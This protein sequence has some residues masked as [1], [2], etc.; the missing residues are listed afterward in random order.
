MSAYIFEMD[1]PKK[2]K[3]NRE[4]KHK[5]FGHQEFIY[6]CLYNI[7]ILQYLFLPGAKILSPSVNPMISLIFARQACSI[8][9]NTGAISYVNMFVFAVA[10][11]HSPAKETISRPVDS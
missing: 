9:M 11:N 1:P 2:R 4:F 10:V 3:K 5:Y 7:L 8:K 6:I